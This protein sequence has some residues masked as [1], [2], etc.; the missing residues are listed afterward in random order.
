MNFTERS[1]M[2]IVTRPD[3]DGVVS[4]ILLRK[5]YGEATPI[6]W[7][8]P[9]EVQ[10]GEVTTTEN[11][12]IA[13]LPYNAPNAL[14]FDHHITNGAPTHFEGCFE[15]APS[16][17]GVVYKYFSE[18]SGYDEL[19][20][21]TDKI[22]SANF[23]A[24]EINNPE[25]YPHILLAMTIDGGNNTDEPYLELL[26]SSLSKMDTKEVMKIEE[27]RK[28]CDM[29]ISQN[30]ELIA[31]LKEHT[32][33]EDGVAIVDYRGMT[34]TPKGNRFLVYSLF[35]EAYVSARVRFKPDNP[36][37]IIVS[38]GHSIINKTCRVNVG[39]LA[40]SIGGGG[41]QAAASCSFPTK[42]AEAN[43]DKI[44]TRLKANIE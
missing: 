39:D 25:H 35:P 2:R 26:T 42:D 19:V 17:A 4:A 10:R 3:Y 16:A 15:I 18:L 22:D 30:R 44:I 12:I 8:E 41:H 11:D 34:E 28:R 1:V 6:Y 5:I 29:V 9:Y 7:V 24:D 13:N 27:V 40:S 23:S 37:E 32:T 33:C 38:L 36:D 14:W 21:E 43:L 31:H 20:K